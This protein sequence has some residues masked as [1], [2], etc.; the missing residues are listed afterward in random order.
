M[1]RHLGPWLHHARDP[2]WLPNLQTISF[3]LDLATREGH[4]YSAEYKPSA[5]QR[6]VNAAV[7]P[8]A[9]HFLKTFSISHPDVRVLD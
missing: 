3:S 5:A 1:V 8:Y 7:G 6:K 4:E 2:S 9:E